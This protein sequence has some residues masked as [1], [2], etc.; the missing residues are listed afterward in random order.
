[1]LAS[2]KKHQNIFRQQHILQ[3]NFYDFSLSTCCLCQYWHLKQRPYCCGCVSV[4]VI[5]P[6]QKS[7]IR[8]QKKSCFFQWNSKWN[9][10]RSSRSSSFLMRV[11]VKSF[12]GR[13]VAL[14]TFLYPKINMVQKKRIQG[15]G[16]ACHWAT[17]RKP[18]K[19]YCLSVQAME[20]PRK[21]SQLGGLFLN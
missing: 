4:A 16:K 7:Q 6:S 10:A 9:T 3:L 11:T 21:W 15:G 5:I 19:I 12:C 2:E 13:N 8:K 14:I 18:H 20:E 1:M 17:L